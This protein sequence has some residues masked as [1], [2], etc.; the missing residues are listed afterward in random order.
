VP[1]GMKGRTS[2]VPSTKR[3]QATKS[4]ETP[5][6]DVNILPALSPAGISDIARNMIGTADFIDVGYHGASDSEM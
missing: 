6:A 4:G 3:D 5:N 1:D 2:N